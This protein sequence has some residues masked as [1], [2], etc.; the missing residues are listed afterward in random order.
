[1]SKTLSLQSATYHAMWIYDALVRPRFPGAS[2]IVETK[3]SHEMPPLRL[4]PEAADLA[5]E[6]FGGAVTLRLDGARHRVYVRRFDFVTFTSDEE[7]RYNFLTLWRE[8]ED[9]DSVT[10]VQ[11]VADQWLERKKR[12]HS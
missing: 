12:R 4:L 9:L 7:A 3:R 8:V 11:R 1:M 5:V 6:L 10:E 2:T